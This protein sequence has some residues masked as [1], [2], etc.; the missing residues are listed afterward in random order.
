MGHRAKKR[1][2]QHF[3]VDG[4]ISRRLVRSVGLSAEDIALEIGPGRGALTKVLLETARRVLAV[5][6]DEELVDILLP[7]FSEEIEAGQFTL[8]V[9]D[10]LKT[11][12]GHLL[13]DQGVTEK[14]RVFG[15]LPYNI[16]TAVIQHL[17]RFRERI[18]DMTFMLQREVGDRILSP[19]G[20]KD[21]GYL[22]VVVQYYCEA[23]RLFGL[24]PGVFRPI[25]KVHSTVVHLKYRQQPL[26]EVS[27]EKRFFEIVSALFAER[28]KTVLNNLKRVAARFEVIDPERTLAETGIDPQRRPE[29][30]S[31]VEFARLANG[32]RAP[33]SEP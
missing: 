29:T 17:I 30:L 1:L 31:L 22:S 32:L 9:N 4:N 28:R 18:E 8:I 33:G 24:P 16:A 5:E 27:S 25:P 21:Y 20:N 19:P 15:N 10:V 6:V 14:I 23:E 13:D 7:Q 11:D 3:L 26:V 2:G 12:V